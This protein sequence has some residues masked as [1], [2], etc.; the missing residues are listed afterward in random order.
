M[1]CSA[2][3]RF[4]HNRRGACRMDS[5]LIGRRLCHYEVVRKLGSGGMGDVYLAHDA[6]LDR[7]VALKF[8]P[9][10]TTT[11]P[12]Q[13]RRLLAEAKAA[14]ALNHPHIATV[15]ELRAAD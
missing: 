15:H 7:P 2:R 12:D 6:M 14:S 3:T 11:V 13:L 5:G 9:S 8:L 10:G 4:G 1:V